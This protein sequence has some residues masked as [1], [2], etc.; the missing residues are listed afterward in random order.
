[1]TISF[2]CYLHTVYINKRYTANIY[3]DT[4]TD[5][6]TLSFINDILTFNG[7][8]HTHIYPANK[9]YISIIHVYTV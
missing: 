9:V 6:D 4:I 7:F 2:D 1:M 8:R 5:G 3:I